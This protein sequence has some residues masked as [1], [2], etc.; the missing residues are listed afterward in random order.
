M[1]KEPFDVIEQILD[2]NMVQHGPMN[3]RIYLMKTAPESE[4]NLP[5]KLIEMAEKHGYSKI[6]AKIPSSHCDQFLQ[7]GYRVEAII[8]GFY[9]GKEA[10]CFLGYYLDKSRAEETDRIFCE[11]CHILALEKK[12]TSHELP[13][14]SLKLRKC[15][16]KDVEEMAAIYQQVFKT[17][18]FPIFDP[19]YL[20]QA[21]SKDVVFFGAESH[22]EMVAL[23][24]AEI[25]YK[26]ASVEMTDFA[27]LP[28]WRGKGLAAYLLAVMERFCQ[29]KELKTAYTIA[30]AVSPAINITFSRSGYQW[31]GRLKNNTQISGCIESMNVW[32][33]KLS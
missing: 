23:S 27:T 29:T 1:E 14:P 4:E 28:S 25:D 12:E 11:K 7:L 6:F 17:Y 21:M 33:K 32:Y 2:G 13:E 31:C 3:D 26:S 16:E 18:P 22:G 9:N 19:A 30:R 8:P 24:S 5:Q 15:E 20:L 10:G